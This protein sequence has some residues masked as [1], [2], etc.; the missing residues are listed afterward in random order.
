M[1]HKHQYIVAEATRSV[2]LHNPEHCLPG[3]ELFCGP[4]RLPVAFGICPD[5]MH[6][7]TAEDDKLNVSTSNLTANQHCYVINDL[8]DVDCFKGKPYVSGW[9]FLRF[10]A[11]VPL[12]S[13]GFVIGSV[14]V[15]DS[16][17]SSGMDVAALDKLAEVA[18]AVASHLDLVQ[19]QTR[20]R[21]S[22]EMVRGLGRFVDG[23]ASTVN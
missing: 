20:L 5:T 4:R 21:R 3:D 10:Y 2:S 23:K 17:P 12:K 11:E 1:D 14:C 18:S 6:V 16:K 15:V 19:T 9:P 7:F 22:Q 8:L 13:N